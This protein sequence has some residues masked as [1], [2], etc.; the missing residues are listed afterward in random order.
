MPIIAEDNIILRVLAE[1]K[2]AKKDINALDDRVENLDESTNKVN[3]SF[4]KLGKIAKAAVGAAVILKGAQ[5]MARLAKTAAAAY[6]EFESTQKSFE[7]LVGDIGEANKLL[8]DLTEF[9]ERTPFAPKEVQ[10]AAKTLLGFGRTVREVK[11][12]IRQL[13]EISAATGA[14]LTQIGLVYGQVASLG[15][16]QGQDALQFIN[17]GIPIYD[18]LSESLGKSVKELKILQSQGKIT[19]EQLEQSI[20]DATEEGGKFFGALEAQ[21]KTIA[22]LQSTIAGRIDS[23]YRTIG[24]KFAPVVR[25]TLGLVN[26]LLSRFNEGVNDIDNS[27]VFK[28][29]AGLDATSQ[30]L[31]AFSNV[32]TSWV[33]YNKEQFRLFGSFA[34]RQILTVKA[35]LSGTPLD[36]GILDAYEVG[37]QNQQARTTA[38]GKSASAYQQIAKNVFAKSY[39]NAL[40]SYSNVLESEGLTGNPVIDGSL[41]ESGA[42]SGQAKKNI[43]LEVSGLI[44]FTDAVLKKVLEQTKDQRVDFLSGIMGVDGGARDLSGFR[45]DAGFDVDDRKWIHRL[46]GL[47]GN[48]IND[49]NRA[50]DVLLQSARSLTDSLVSEEIRRTDLLIQASRDRVSEFQRI[51]G[52]G[53]AEQLQLEEERQRKLLEQRED[54][55]QKQKRLDAL[56]ITA[57]NAVIVSELLTGI[58]KTFRANPVVGIITGLAAGAVI[59]STIASIRGA[60]SSGIPAFQHGTEF[61]EGAGG[62][63]NIHAKL[64]RGERVVDK[65]KN[66]QLNKWGVT[67]DDLVPLVGS[68][69]GKYSPANIAKSDTVSKSEFKKL[70]QGLADVKQAIYGIQFNVNIDEDGIGVAAGNYLSSKQ[71]IKSLMS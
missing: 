30:S 60:L 17:A 62:I 29:A 68:A 44:K 23:L 65:R 9:S 10:Q 51:A 35:L 49:F 21:S 48:D 39:K 16:L 26:Q 52:D 54:Y 37:F 34:Q 13:G 19:F 50:G 7:I 43:E 46:L 71:R 24:E 45:Q 8:K 28:I 41:T 67:N 56:Q 55:L 14:D 33:N 5:A 57:N 6:A 1:T 42:I 47:E 66:A 3:D 22:G 59:A 70:Q 63:D 53:N 38:A 18:L 31:T 32:V 25:S 4:A 11:T 20:K 64:T 2:Q 69:L 15:K 40:E 58:A 36:R 12:D 61:V 27:F